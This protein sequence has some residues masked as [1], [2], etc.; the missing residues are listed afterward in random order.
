MANQLK[1]RRKQPTATEEVIEDV[2]E[3]CTPK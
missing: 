3:V 1:E 2:K